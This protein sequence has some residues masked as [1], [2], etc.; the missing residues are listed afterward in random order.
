[1]TDQDKIKLVETLNHHCNVKPGQH[2]WIGVNKDIY[3]GDRY[4]SDTEA[5]RRAKDAIAQEVRE[6][7]ET[8]E[9]LEKWLSSLEEM[10]NKYH[11]DGELYR[12]MREA[13]QSA[14]DLAKIIEQQKAHIKNLDEETIAAANLI[15]ILSRK[16]ERSE[17]EQVRQAKLIE[18]QKADL[19]NRLR[20]YR[21]DEGKLIYRGDKI[22]ELEK[23]LREEGTKAARLK[24]MLVNIA[25]Q[26]DADW[27][28]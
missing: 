27:E 15:A 7:A 21:E 9:D 25:A 3:Q 6:Q 20:L 5:I 28:E 10:P 18:R 23:Q 19:T 13:E 16:L 17:V 11:T 8:I 4:V 26:F 1:M 14:E 22:L 12:R 2:Y 24:N